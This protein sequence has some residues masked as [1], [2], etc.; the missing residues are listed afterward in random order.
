MRLASGAPA[1]PDPR[2]LDVAK[3]LRASGIS[4]QEFERWFWDLPRE[5]L[6]TGVPSVDVQSW[7]GSAVGDW[8]GVLTGISPRRSG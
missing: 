3:Y 2:V 5:S 7:A 6:I 1:E 8:E 4:E